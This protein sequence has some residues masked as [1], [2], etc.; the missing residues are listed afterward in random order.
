MAFALIQA[1]LVWKA[2]CLESKSAI[3]F[4]E[5]TLQAPALDACVSGKKQRAVTF[6]TGPC[7]I[8]QTP[9]FRLKPDNSFAVFPKNLRVEF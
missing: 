7:S 9:I 3:F 8:Y 1:L 6:V 5:K 4:G 2:S